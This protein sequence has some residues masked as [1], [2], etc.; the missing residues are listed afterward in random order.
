MK[1]A[2][3]N[4]WGLGNRPAVRGLL[5]FYNAEKV[6]VLFLSET[7]LKEKGMQRFKRLLGMGNMVVVDL[8]GKGGGGLQ[9]YG[10]ERSMWC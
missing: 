2:A 7:K 5:G 9:C 1:L 3:W 8:E 6:D 10:G 4:C